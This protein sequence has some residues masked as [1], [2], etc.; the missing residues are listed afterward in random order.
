MPAASFQNPGDPVDNQERSPLLS[1]PAVEREQDASNSM[2]T[3]RALLFQ[4][5][6]GNVRAMATQVSAL[7]LL[8]ETAVDVIRSCLLVAFI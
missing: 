3:K 1:N 5:L 8:L 6:F 4:N 7:L 2:P